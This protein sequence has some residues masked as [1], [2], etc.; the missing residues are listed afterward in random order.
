MRDVIAY[1]DGFNLYHA[2]DDLEKPHLKWL[3]LNALS[4]RLGGKHLRSQ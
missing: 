3:D 4:K 1:I 2:I